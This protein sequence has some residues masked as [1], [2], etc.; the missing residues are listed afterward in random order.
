MNYY[1]L[2][3]FVSLGCLLITASSGFSVSQAVIRVQ[4]VETAEEWDALADIRFNEWIQEDGGTS[5]HAFRSA[6]REIYMEERPESLLFLATR[7]PEDSRMKVEDAV[8]GAA[9]MSPYELQPALSNSAPFSGLYVTDVVTASHY[10]RQGIAGKMMQRLEEH[11][12]VRGVK[13]YLFANTL[14]LANAVHQNHPLLT[15]E[16]VSR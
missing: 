5:R 4:P 1:H 10:R 15:I 9:E 6:T 14:L 7:E 16:V 2:S 13:R 8:V 12:A 3:L 11:A